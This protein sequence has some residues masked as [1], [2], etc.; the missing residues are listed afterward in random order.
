MEWVIILILIVFVFS[1]IFLYVFFIKK[2]LE[3]LSTVVVF[4]Y[5]TIKSDQE[6]VRTLK[7]HIEKLQYEITELKANNG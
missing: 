6:L 1:L 5:K 7:K 4:M 2:K 3:S